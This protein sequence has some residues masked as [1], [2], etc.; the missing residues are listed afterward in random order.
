V[1]V[2]LAKRLYRVNNFKVREPLTAK[3][4][5]SI[6]RRSLKNIE[7]YPIC[8]LNQAFASMLIQMGWQNQ[9]LLPFRT[10]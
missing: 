4:A 6:N 9:Q 10:F 1:K 3:D 2:S 5:S 8:H 7:N